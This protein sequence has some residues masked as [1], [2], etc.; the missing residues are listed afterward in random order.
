MYTDAQAILYQVL[1]PS[2]Y[3]RHLAFGSLSTFQ[4]KVHS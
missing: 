3:F 1:F 2:G 4:G